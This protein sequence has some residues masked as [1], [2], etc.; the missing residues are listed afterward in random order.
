MDVRCAVLCCFVILLSLLHIR[1]RIIIATE[2]IQIL[3]YMRLDG[4]KCFWITLKYS[5]IANTLFNTDWY[6]FLFALFATGS[7]SFFSFFLELMT[8]QFT[9][10]NAFHMCRKLEYIIIRKKD[11]FLSHFPV[12]EKMTDFFGRFVQTLSNWC[13]KSKQKKK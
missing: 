13:A 10:Q 9:V 1:I 8:K 4:F 6:S 2:Q 3:F 5:L 11:N 12:D 7:F